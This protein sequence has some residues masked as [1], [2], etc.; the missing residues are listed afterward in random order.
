M[1]NLATGMFAMG[2]THWIYKLDGN[3]STIFTLDYFNDAADMLKSGDMITVTSPD[4][5]MILFVY[6]VT[7]GRVFTKVMSRS[8]S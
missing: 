5:G 3:L 1:R 6:R 7:N 4:N 2:F 8:Y